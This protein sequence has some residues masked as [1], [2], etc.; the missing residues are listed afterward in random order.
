M[1]NINEQK[2]AE[3][4]LRVVKQCI[5]E[6][7]TRLKSRRETILEERKY[8]NDYFNELKDDEKKDLLDN[9]VLDTNAYTYSLQLVARLSKQLKEP[10]FAGFTFKEDE[11]DDKETYYLSIHTLRDPDTGAI[12]TTDWRAPVA[13]LYYESEP[14][15]AKF[16]APVGEI[17]G[18]LS[19]KKRYV[20]KDGKLLKSTEIGMPSDD[21]MLCEVLK[22][23]SD[24]HMKTILQT[25]QKEQ[26][27][28][29]R[30]YVEGVAVIEGVAG[31]GKSS[32]ALHKTAYVLYAFRDRLK[33]GEITIISPNKVFSE[34]ISSV[35]PDLGEENV[36]EYL[37]EDV[38]EYALKDVEDYKFTDRLTQQEIIH[39]GAPE[40]AGVKRLSEYKSTMAFR[41][42]VNEYVKYLRSNIFK[43]EDLSL[44]EEGNRVVSAELLNDLFYSMYSDL[45][46]M[47][48]TEEMAQFIAEQNKIRSPELKEKIKMELNFMLTSMSAPTLYRQ[49]YSKYSDMADYAPATEYWEDACAV[50]IIYAALYEPD[51]AIRNFYVIADE[52][53]D[54]VPIFIELLKIVYKGSNMLFVGDG[55]Q[56]IMGNKGDFVKD[57]KEIIPRRPFRKYELTVNYRSTKQIVEYAAKYQSNEMNA[58]CVR[59]GETPVEITVD[60][61]EK[62]AA[63]AKKYVKQAV[64]KGYENI[65]IVCK[66]NSEAKK[67]ETAM[68]MEYALTSK[69][70]FK[71][72]PLYL[73][74]G[75]E[76][77]CA[78]VWDMPEDMMYTAC[79]RAMHELI[80]I[81][82]KKVL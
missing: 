31:S 73:A 3:E 39:S 29:V 65:A 80:V 9:E 30:D 32:I 18:E 43:A 77:D 26:Y 72:L 70:N 78:I 11:F 16:T 62:A 53:Q 81:N 14:G 17:S 49:M 60:G 68:N 64:Q 63:E 52:A 20:F 79:T 38:I 76:F 22:Q 8:F 46:I 4:T 19:E 75:L 48:R 25:I 1:S 58:K 56:K 27:K 28:I 35:L 2:Y 5:D 34:Y 36:M 82:K 15:K 7:L 41:N 6:E 33:Y 59:D 51:L 69:I 23:N 40:S 24:T 13:S 10:Y 67:I 21:E 42:K 37:F 66:S 54:Y 55:N 12:M 50:A 57:I 47:K 45:P 61:I 71:V 74:K 44:D